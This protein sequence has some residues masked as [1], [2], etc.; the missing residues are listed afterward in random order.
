MLYF[1]SHNLAGT[2]TSTFSPY[3]SPAVVEASNVTKHL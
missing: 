1:E 2:L 3:D